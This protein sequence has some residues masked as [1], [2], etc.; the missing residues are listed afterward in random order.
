MPIRKKIL[1]VDNDQDF[2]IL[3]KKLLINENFEFLIA[4]TLSEGMILLEKENPEFVFLDNILPD[5][6]G[7]EKTEYILHNY[8]ETQLNLLSRLNVPKTS[9]STFRILEKPLTSN[10]LFSCLNNYNLK[11]V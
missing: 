2:G 3:M 6:L 11:T 7:W 4:S 5:G 1:L 10:E 8:P 9:A